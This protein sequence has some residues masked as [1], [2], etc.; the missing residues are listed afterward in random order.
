V[1]LGSDQEGTLAGLD[2][3]NRGG[4]QK[5]VVLPEIVQVEPI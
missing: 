5:L 2:V 1:K 4:L 3:H